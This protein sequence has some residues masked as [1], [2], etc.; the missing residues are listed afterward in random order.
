ML[1][2][3]VGPVAKDFESRKPPVANKVT[4]SADNGNVAAN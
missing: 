2:F 4:D 1:R 3:P